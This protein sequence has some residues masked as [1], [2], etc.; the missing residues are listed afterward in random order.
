MVFDKKFVGGDF[1]ILLLYVDDML[2]VG[3]DPK[4][5][6]ILKKTITVATM[7]T[8]GR[9]IIVITSITIT[10][11]QTDG[12]E[13]ITKGTTGRKTYARSDEGHPTTTAE[14]HVPHGPNHHVPRS[15][16]NKNWYR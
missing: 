2:I 10:I 9:M 14:G 1:L 3:R 12:T 13:E 11:T 8:I 6:K 7:I 16:K 5:I 4:K 15:N